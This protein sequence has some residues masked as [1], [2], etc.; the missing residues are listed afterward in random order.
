[1][2]SD[3]DGI[4]DPQDR[5]P[6]AAEDR[7]RYR[8]EDGCPD[9]DN[10][11][12]GVLDRRDQCPDRPESVNGYEDEDGCPDTPPGPVPRATVAEPEYVRF[13]P[14]STRL[15]PASQSIL[16][17]MAEMLRNSS[18]AIRIEGHCDRRERN[19]AVLSLRRARS[20]RDYLIKQGVSGDKVKA[21]GFGST[22]P[23]APSDTEQDRRQ[24][25]R[26]DFTFFEPL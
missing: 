8:D 24:N 9:A 23:L 6:H 18:G 13:A 22:R 10:D 3:S 20:V 12:D 26:V 15:T 2:D 11:G 21:A 19:R 5:C 17:K 4:P 16:N 14:Q 1:V 7:D 25:R